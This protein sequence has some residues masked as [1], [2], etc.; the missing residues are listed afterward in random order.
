MLTLPPKNG[1]FNSLYAIHRVGMEVGRW[2]SDGVHNSVRLYIQ[3]RYQQAIVV[4]T[5]SD[6]TGVT[7]RTSNQPRTPQ[8][9]ASSDTTRCCSAGRDGEFESLYAIHSQGMEV[10]RLWLD[11]V[12]NSVLCLQYRYEQP[13]VVGDLSD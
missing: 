6:W 10:G 2:W 8:T 3:Y 7:E 12:Q 4:C 1:E 11:G 9:T 5:L 13:I